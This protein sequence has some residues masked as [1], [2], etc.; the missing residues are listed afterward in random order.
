MHL[1]KYLFMPDSW[2]RLEWQ[3]FFGFLISYE[4]Y[5]PS[6]IYIYIYI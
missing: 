2:S 3:L 5:L 1:H 4:N 6:I